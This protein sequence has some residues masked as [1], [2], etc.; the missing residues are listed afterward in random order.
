MNISGIRPSHGFYSYNTIKIYQLRNQ[1]IAAA[2]LNDI[3]VV[4]DIEEENIFSEYRSF[5][6]DTVNTTSHQIEDF[7]L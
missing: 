7:A 1:Q 3:I 5:S 6:K 4:V 2:N